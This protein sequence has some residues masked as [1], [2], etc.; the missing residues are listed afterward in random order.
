MEKILIINYDI[1]S[2]RHYHITNIFNHLISNQSIKYDFINM[3]TLILNSQNIDDLKQYFYTTYNSI[4]KYIVAFSGVG[5][6]NSIIDVLSQVTNLVLIID[7]IHHA[8]SIQIPRIKV[9]KKTAIVFCSYSYEFTRWG[10][11][12][13]TNLYFFPHSARWICEYNQNPINKILISGRI[14]DI[15]PDREFAHNKALK[16][17]SIFDILK[18]NVSYRDNN[19]NDDS[20]Y[21]KKFYDYLNKYLCCYVDTAR[22]YI[23]AKIFEICAA[24]SLL[25]CMDTN[26]KHIMNE[27]GFE[28]DINYISCTRENFMDKARW[29]VNNKNIKKI[30]TIRQNGYELIK[31]NHTWENRMKYLLNI[32]EK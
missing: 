18:C 20:I 6:F 30:N 31:N 2:T 10:L 16:Y 24:G 8:N 5:G 32:I 29:I 25:F 3:E 7:D 4:P 12:K 9:I 19:T 22:D 13:P 21:G 15:Y 14:S 26:V 17:P 27:L 23:L 1:K 11:P 28:D